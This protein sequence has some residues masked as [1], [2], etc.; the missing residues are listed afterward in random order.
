MA[1]SRF[2]WKLNQ[3]R[4]ADIS[5]QYILCIQLI[6]HIWTVFTCSSTCPSPCILPNYVSQILSTSNSPL[7]SSKNVHHFQESY[8]LQE[9]HNYVFGEG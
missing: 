4:N 7:T 9:W 2:P 5:Y 3:Q 6:V 8:T 1:T